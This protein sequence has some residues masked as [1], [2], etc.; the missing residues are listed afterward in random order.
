MSDAGA[1]AVWIIAGSSRARGLDYCITLY[2][3]L[4]CV[5]LAR[6]LLGWGRGVVQTVRKQSDVYDA[7]RKVG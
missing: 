4:Y 6:A 5:W 7:E 1:E 3:V 2:R